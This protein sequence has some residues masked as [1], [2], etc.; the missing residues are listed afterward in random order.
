M[1]EQH[2]GAAAEVHERLDAKIFLARTWMNHGRALLARGRATDRERA[3]GLLK[4]AI[5]L[6]RK[7]GGGAVVRDAEALLADS[8]TV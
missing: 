1:A 8:L 2:F 7:S 3:T 5:E 6:A 4:N